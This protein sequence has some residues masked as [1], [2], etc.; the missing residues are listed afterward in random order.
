MKNLIAVLAIGILALCACAAQNTVT[1]KRNRAGQITAITSNADAAH[2]RNGRERIG[3]SNLP[4]EWLALWLGIGGY[5]GHNTGAHLGYNLINLDKDEN[6]EI[7]HSGGVDD[8][9]TT[10]EN[11]TR[12]VNENQNVSGQVDVDHNYSGVV[13]VNGTG[14][15]DSEHHL[16]WGP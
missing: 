7:H 2:Y 11:I 16:I 1:V 10:D 9:L 14:G 13:N 3:Y 6:R 4:N 15:W 8:T 12:T 5:L